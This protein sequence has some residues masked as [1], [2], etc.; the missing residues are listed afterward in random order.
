MKKVVFMSALTIVL[1]VCAVVVLNV[2]P[3][4]NLSELSLA[5]IEALAT[6]A[7]AETGPV[8]VFGDA[9][10]G[11]SWICACE[12]GGPCPQDIA[13]LWRFL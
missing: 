6:K 9:F 8:Y 7:P 5:N 12:D 10:V 2:R 11:Y 3:Q 1:I 4:S 13:E